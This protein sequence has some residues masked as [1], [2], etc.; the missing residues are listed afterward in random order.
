V[1]YSLQEVRAASESK[2]D[3][4]FTNN[5]QMFFNYFYIA[6]SSYK[7]NERFYTIN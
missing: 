2:V 6:I 4:F 7:D 3:S 1:D 5:N